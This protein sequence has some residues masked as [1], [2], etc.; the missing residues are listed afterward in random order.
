MQ[1]NDTKRHVHGR[2]SSDC[3]NEM[4][5]GHIARVCVGA[6]TRAWSTNTRTLQVGYHSALQK[7]THTHTH[8]PRVHSARSLNACCN[9]HEDA[10]LRADAENPVRDMHSRQISRAES[11][12][13]NALMPS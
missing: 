9:K 10:I 11:F 3:V 12:R 1:L 5:L 13:F 7:C 6:R 2:G 8:T 4:L